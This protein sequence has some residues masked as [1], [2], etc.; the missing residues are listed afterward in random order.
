MT[1]T[2]ITDPIL[3][4]QRGLIPGQEIVSIL[5]ERDNA[6]VDP[7]GEDLWKG[8]AITIPDPSSS[9]EQLTVV[10]NNAADTSAGIGVKT[11]TIHYLDDTGAQQTETVTMAGETPVNTTAT[12]ISFVNA[13]HT[14][15]KGTNNVAKGNIKLY[16]TGDA[17]RVYRKIE[18]GGN[19]DM[20]CI[21]K[22]PLN[23]TLQMRCWHAEVS[24]VDDVS[25]RIRSTDYAGVLK[26]GIYLFKGVTQLT[27]ASSGN[28]EL[29]TTIPSLSK[30]KMTAWC[31]SPNNALSGGF[32]GILIDN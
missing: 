1:Y 25:V 7:A 13:F 2:P 27:N 23:K 4:I 28:L 15:S 16:R 29:Y 22:V 30:I 10:S 21:Y 3:A 14:E 11:V 5:G 18:A 8:N 12:N 31:D 26:E 32:I 6:S 24:S 19:W 20:T 17:T 9:G